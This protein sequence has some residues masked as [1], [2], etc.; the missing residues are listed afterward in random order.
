MERHEHAALDGLEEAQL[1]CGMAAEVAE[2]VASVHALRRSGQAEQDVRLVVGKEFLV[3]GGSGVV[4]FIDDDV[5]IGIRRRLFPPFLRVK[6]LDGEK[7]VAEIVG[8]CR[9]VVADEER[10]EVLVAQDAAEAGEALREDFLAVRDEEQAAGLAR[11][12]FA[13]AQVVEG[14]EDGLA[15][16][17]GSDD[18][19]A[20]VAAQLALGRDLIE[21]GAL[22]GKGTDGEKIGGGRFVD[23]G[24]VP[25]G[26]DGGS[27]E[28]VLFQRVGLKVR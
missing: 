27:E 7:K 17:C 13:K 25:L 23:G 12:R 19:V 8:R 16:S 5:V 9:L 4:D 20:V 28:V 24:A 14:G 6:G 15:G 1:G 11:M 21:E 3:R 22:I 2:D 18:E 26:V 10:A